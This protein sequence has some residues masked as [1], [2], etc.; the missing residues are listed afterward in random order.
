MK[1]FKM[2]GLNPGVQPSQGWDETGAERPMFANEPADQP[3][4]LQG[5]APEGQQTTVGADEQALLAEIEALRAELAEAETR[6]TNHYEQFVRASAEI[7]NVRRRGREDVDKAKKFAIEGFAESLLPV[8][9]SLEMALTVETPSIE[10]IRE[11][12]QATLRQLLQAFER[13][14]LKVVDP[15]GERFDPNAQQAISMV[16]SPDVPANHVVSVLQ[17]GYLI[18]D[19]VLRPAMVVVS[20]GG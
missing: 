13:N 6:A 19:R 2:P 18:N 1:E 20:Q 14:H 17:K 7:E 4:D 5:L 11:G 15:V 3:Q 8:C 16:P 12:V 10:N 9:D